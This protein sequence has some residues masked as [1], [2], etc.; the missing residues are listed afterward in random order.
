MGAN[1]KEMLGS[2]GLYMPHWVHPTWEKDPNLHPTFKIGSNTQQDNK[3]FIQSFL[4]QGSNPRFRP[5]LRNFM[6]NSI[7]WT[8]MWAFIWKVEDFD[9]QI[10]ETLL[11][12]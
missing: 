7:E 5:A 8:V 3:L 9:A 11:Y 6:D 2:N 10:R 1:S 12:K 4:K